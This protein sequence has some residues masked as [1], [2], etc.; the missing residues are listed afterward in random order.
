MKTQN[1]ALLALALGFILAACANATSPQPYGDV[2][3]QSPGFEANLEMSS[4]PDQ[5][6]V[7]CYQYR[8]DTL[9]CVKVQ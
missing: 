1:K 4:K 9:S 3:N 7:V 2:S 6:G 5:Y 8:R